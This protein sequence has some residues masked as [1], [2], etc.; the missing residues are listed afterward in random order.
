MFVIHTTIVYRSLPDN[1][2][3]DVYLFMYNICM[4]Y[5]FM[6]DLNCMVTHL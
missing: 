3:K 2:I 4:L 5:N 6:I 1:R